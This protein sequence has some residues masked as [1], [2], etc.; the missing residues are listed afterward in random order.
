MPPVALIYCGID[1]AGYG[2]MIGPLCVG[3]SVFRLESWSPGQKAP[4]LWD[5]LASGICRKPG[6]K[7][8]RI[9]VADS[10]KLKLSNQSK[11]RHP[12]IH[13]ERAVLAFA[14]SMGTETQTDQALFETLGTGFEGN[15]WYASEPVNLPLGSTID[16]IN[17]ATNLVRTA[18][19]EAG[20]ELQ[21][22]ACKAIGEQEFNETVRSTG[23]K[24]E[25]TLRAVGHHLRRIMEEFTGE[26]IRAVCD[27][28]GGRTSYGALLARELSADVRV[29]E[30]SNRLSR[31]EIRKSRDDT[32]M[33]VQ[34]MPEAED[35]HL[36][37]ALASMTA[38]L[39][40][41][42]AM[43]RFNKYWCNR[44]PEIKPTAGYTQDA[45]RWLEDAG[46]QVTQAERAAMV[47]LA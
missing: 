37:V 21:T 45:R 1:E 19:H 22:L 33:V 6:D 24:A 41:E 31:Y 25:T 9:A 18:A 14:G 7:Q 34:F 11:T 35:S 36:P 47:R 38:K 23:T 4:N 17:I 20:L 43:A 32:P 46:P 15:P 39:V 30:E 27:R 10:K 2:P 26:H 28:L 5:H 29:V 42:L 13:L 44:I 12:L 16:Q 8:G 3:L 40:R